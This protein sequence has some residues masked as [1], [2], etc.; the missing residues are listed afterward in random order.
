EIS[1]AEA[2]AEQARAIAA[3]AEVDRVR[4]QEVLAA[5]ADLED[6]PRLVDAMERSEKAEKVVVDARTATEEARRRESELSGLI[7]HL[8]AKR[9]HAEELEGICS[10]C[11]QPVTPEHRAEML[12]ELD[13]ELAARRAEKEVA[14][15]QRRD[16]LILQS[17]AELE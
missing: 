11:G 14:E 17:R 3:E 7:A 13:A 8:E 10:E 12:A 15:T 16:A 5:L 4:L 2:A 9:A 1:E 6:A